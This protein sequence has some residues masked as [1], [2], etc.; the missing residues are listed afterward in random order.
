MAKR[1]AAIF[2]VLSFYLFSCTSSQKSYSPLKKYDRNSLQEDYRLLKN[3]LEKKHPSLY[4]YTSKDSMDLFFSKYEAEIRDSMTEQQFAWQV[5]APLVSKIKCGHTSVSMSK[6]YIRWADRK[7]FP[8]FPLYMKVWEDS[9]LTMIN[10]NR[11][12][13]V[14]KKGVPIT[15]INGLSMQSL[16]EKISGYLPKDGDANSI[17]YI[18]MS[19]NFPYYHRNIFGL[20]KTY[21][22]TYLDS[23][24]NSNTAELPLFAPVKDSTKKAPVVKVKQPKPP[25]QKR[26]T[27]YRSLQIDSSGQFAVMTLNT[28]SK[29]QLRRFF[30]RSFKELK[31]KRIN[32]LVL[33]VRLNGG[34]RVG[35]STLLTKYISRTPFKVADTLYAVSKNL[36]PYSRY[37]EGKF[38][39]NLELFFITRKKKDGLYHIGFLEK[40]LFKPKKKNHYDGKLYVITAGPT[41]S[42]AALFCNT[43]KGQEGIKLVG[44]ETGGGWYGN[45][46]VM[47]PD[48]ILPNTK[49][50]VRLPLFRMVQYKHVP[51]HKSSG[52]VPDIYVGTSYDALMKGYDRKMTVV[53]EMIREGGQ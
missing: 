31:E 18:R 14:I 6:A 52:I 4:W 30:R 19:A 17:N 25:K 3:I 21:R 53:K 15:S 28:F 47:I 42:A 50:T 26:L 33:D 46:G 45:N 51:E 2:F 12:D 8:S 29:G 32:N 22:V 5:L 48:I 38:F 10:L 44:E 11:K 35:L 7:T 40:K 20:T 49:I 36:K 43:I 24:G 34:G 27:V 9:M 1:F 16:V 39:N 13:S 41:F 37:I 23:L